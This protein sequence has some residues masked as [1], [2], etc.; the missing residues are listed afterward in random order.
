VENT[1]FEVEED[2]ENEENDD[3]DRFENAIFSFLN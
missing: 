3:D 1:V 2:D